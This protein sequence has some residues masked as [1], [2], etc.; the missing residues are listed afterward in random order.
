[1]PL[2]HLSPYYPKPEIN[3]KQF[4]SILKQEFRLFTGNRIMMTLY[5]GGPILFGLLFGA[6]YTKGRVTDLP[7]V[8]VDK[9]RSPMSARLIDMLEENEVLTIKYMAYDNIDIQEMFISE[10]VQGAVVIPADFESNLLQAKY[11]EVNTYINNGNILTSGYTNR[12]ISLVVA[13]LNAFVS[14]R[15]GKPQEIIHLNTFRLFNPSSNYLM[16][17][18]P[19]YLAIILQSVILVVIAMSFT[20]E[21][22]NNG[23]AQ[24]IQHGVNSLV[25]LFGKLSIYWLLGVVILLIYGLYFPLF[26]LHLPMDLTGT[27]VISALFIAALSFQGIIAGLI[28]R[29][30]LKVIQFLMILTMPAYIASGF[31]WPFNH[32]AWPAQIYGILFPYMPFVNGFRILLIEHGTLPDITQFVLLQ[33][34]QLV[35]YFLIAWGLLKY[36]MKKNYSYG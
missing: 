18:W 19:S 14:A 21:A 24:F 13:T 10:G 36:K 2:L 28:F 12:A 8:V 22:G 6:L 1:M 26:R 9:D 34:I 17:I 7:I 23:A 33:V 20:A 25:I 27:L 29:S 31:S 15:T 32:D 4:L 16:Y 11:P 30:Q 3:M 5:L 35:L